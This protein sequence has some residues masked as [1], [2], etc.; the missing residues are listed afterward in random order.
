[1]KKVTVYTKPLC[2]YCVRA[3]SLLDKKGAEVEEISAA[4]DR[5]RRSE[6]VE[7]SG[8][9]ST[10][11]QIFIGDEHVGGCDDLMALERDGRLDAMLA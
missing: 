8:G 6:M 11:P 3:L 10:F 2:P 1:M 7:R 5:D 4:Y 9:R